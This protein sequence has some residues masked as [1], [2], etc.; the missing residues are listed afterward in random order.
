MINGQ[1]MMV[2]TGQSKALE[3]VQVLQEALQVAERKLASVVEER[4]VRMREADERLALV[5]AQ[6]KNDVAAASEASASATVA[7]TEA[8]GRAAR[9]AA[10]LE[11]AEERTIRAARLLAEAEGREASA[12]QG[13]AEAKQQLALVQAEQIDMQARQEALQQALKE[14]EAKLMLQTS[15][16]A[17]LH[18][19]VDSRLKDM[20]VKLADANGK[21]REAVGQAAKALELHSIVLQ[22][23]EERG[24][25]LEAVQAAL[26]AAAAREEEL[27]KRVSDNLEALSAATAREAELTKRISDL[28]STQNQIRTINAEVR[29][30]VPK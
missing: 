16:Q 14:A 5:T 7:A 8:E 17:L 2:R 13:Q 24:Q 12:E 15:E 27:I 28:E 4:E 26:A 29:A 21:L 20:E 30:E 3:Q 10:A 11:E 25:A 9:T 22:G 1:L 18:G 23:S 6:W 19:D